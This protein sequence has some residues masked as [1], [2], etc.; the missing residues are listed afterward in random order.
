MTHLSDLQLI[1]F[2][3][4]GVS[5]STWEKGGL[6]DREVALYLALRPHLR[7]ITFVTYGDARDLDF[8]VRLG[9]IRIV[10]NRWRLNRRWYMRLL[11]F[12]LHRNLRGPV[13]FKSNQIN[14]A[15]APLD[16]AQRFGQ[17]GIT[18][19]GY[20]ISDRMAWHQGD[21][22]PETRTARKREQI[23]FSRAQACVVSAP[24]M[25]T[26]LERDYAIPPGH[27]RVI[28]NYV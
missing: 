16:L 23:V 17:P 6:F 10:C 7:G 19:C 2:F 3:T 20:L 26:V 12:L 14:G 18:R 21:Q 24:H 15:E 11:P 25:K 22:A 8:A 28:P 1:L 13:I 5:L 9:D 27:V 4:D